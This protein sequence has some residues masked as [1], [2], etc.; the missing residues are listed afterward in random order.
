MRVMQ[1]VRIGAAEVANEDL[2]P[3]R[4]GELI[5]RR[6]ARVE[7]PPASV[8]VPR[9]LFQRIGGSGGNGT[10]PRGALGF[11]GRSVR[12]RLQEIVRQLSRDERP[13]SRPALEVTFG[14]KLVEGAEDGDPR[15]PE[16]GREASRRWNPLTSPEPA[17]HDR[18]AVTFVDLSVERNVGISIDA[19]RGGEERRK[20]PHHAT[21]LVLVFRRQLALATDRLS[22]QAGRGISGRYGRRTVG[23]P[24]RSR[25]RRNP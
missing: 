23:R 13:G 10:R 8:P 5:D 25:R 7:G 17:V 12:R 16:L 24:G 11:D 20:G 1:Q 14:E 22:G 9:F 3:D 18:I 21:I 4:Q 2:R 15:D 6:L 19:D